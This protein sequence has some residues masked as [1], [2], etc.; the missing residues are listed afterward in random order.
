[1]RDT[2]RRVLYPGGV[3]GIRP[4][5]S[6]WRNMFNRDCR[7]VVEE[8]ELTRVVHPAARVQESHS[9]WMT[10]GVL[11]TMSVQWLACEI[12]LGGW[13]VGPISQD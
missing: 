7:E 10:G 9:A 13:M 12:R 4:E 1:V 5:G 3:G 6:A 8:M 11:G 2:G